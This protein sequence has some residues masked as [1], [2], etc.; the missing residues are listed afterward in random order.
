LFF[1]GVEMS[2]SPAQLAIEA[3]D[4]VARGMEVKWGVSRLPR[5]VAPEWSAKFHSQ[6]EKLN[7]AITDEASGGGWEAS[8]AV[9]AQATRM[10]S[11]WLKLDQVATEA[12]AEPIAPKRIEG[13]LPDGRLLVVVD[14]PESAW[15][16]AHED[17]AA[18][19]WSIEEICRV[20]WNF[21]LVNEAKRVWP[22]ARVEQVRVDPERT[23]PPVDWR[24]GDDLPDSLKAWGAG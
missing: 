8:Q 20:L 14:G 23:K 24:N 6:R 15:A 9:I 18:V 3:L 5:L 13:R 11:A 12:G 16:V 19:V 2:K 4:E 10:Q 22:G 1:G 17:R 21:E 7:A